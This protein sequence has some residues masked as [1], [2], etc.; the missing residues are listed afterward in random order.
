MI[1]TEM[2]RQEVL[3]MLLSRG[4]AQQ[5]LFEHA[6]RLR[7]EHLGDHAVVRGV[8]EITNLCRVNCSY[9]PMR[10]DNTKANHIF[11]LQIDEILEAAKEIKA[12]GIKVVFFQG[13]EVPQTTKLLAEVIPRVKD[14]FNGEVEVLLN[15]GIKSRD[16]YALLRKSGA[17]SVILKYETSD[18]EL[19]LYHREEPLE[20]RLECIRTLQS[21]GYKV[22][23]G[24][25]IGLP[26]QTLETLADDVL[27]SRS[28]ALDMSSSS[29]FQPAPETPLADAMP[30]DFDTS[31]NTIAAM[32]I[33]LPAALIPSVSALEALQPGGQLQ[34]LNAGGN[35]LTIN[36]TPQQRGKD[37][38][39]Y[40][41]NRYI[42]RAG[43]VWNLLAEAG[44]SSSLQVA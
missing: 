7:R 1:H 3:R 11:Y 19:H 17:D 5:A 23:S 43:H 27:L 26:G 36:F 6:R 38:L 14:L 16:E 13:G 40:G 10:R 24:T 29:P 22:G 30:G 28:L 44:L 9:C 2:D 8:I 20:G 31:L 15:I 42:V 18:A 4:A 41:K 33:A 35:V 34:G 37:Y 21:L 39:I 25:I 32:R 12:R